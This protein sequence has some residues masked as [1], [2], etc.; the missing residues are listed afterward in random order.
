MLKRP[1]NFAFTIYFVARIFLETVPEKYPNLLKAK[2]APTSKAR[3]HNLVIIR[4]LKTVAASHFNPVTISDII[5]VNS[6]SSNLIF[7]FGVDLFCCIVC[8]KKAYRLLSCI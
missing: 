8:F 2:F 7:Q 6:T 5:D 4:I 1:I 3:F